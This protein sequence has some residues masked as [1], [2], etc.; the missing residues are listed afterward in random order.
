[1]TLVAT[2]EVHHTRFIDYNGRPT[3]ALPTFTTDR[4]SMVALYRS[5][6]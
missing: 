1:V 3:Q 6:E 4:D 5:V 2:F